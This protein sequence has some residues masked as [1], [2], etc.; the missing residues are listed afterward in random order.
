[1]DSRSNGARPHRSLGRLR[2]IIFTVVAVSLTGLVVL[3]YVGSVIDGAELDTVD[4]RFNIRGSNGA[5]DDVVV[6]GIDDVT[7]DDLQERWP[8]RRRFHAQAIDAL[9]KAGAKAIAY[10]IQFTEPSNPRDDNALIDAVDRA[11]GVVLATTEVD[12]KGHANFFGG[13]GILKEIGARAGNSNFLND[14][15]GV[16]RRMPFGAAGRTS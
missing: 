1:M 3:A 14:E 13:G 2:L 4:Q 7:F 15:D 11:N 5:P 10:D 6:V 16:I 12:A 8:F 9:S